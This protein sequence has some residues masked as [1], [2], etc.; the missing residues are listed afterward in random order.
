MFLTR[1]RRAQK[2]PSLCS[3]H[4]KTK[5]TLRKQKINQMLNKR[6]FGEEA[7][8]ESLKEAIVDF[9]SKATFIPYNPSEK[10]FK[11]L[12][13]ML[14]SMVSEQCNPQ[15]VSEVIEGIK[16][17]YYT[18]NDLS[19]VEK[20]TYDI[21][22]ILIELLKMPSILSNEECLCNILSTLINISTYRTNFTKEMYI[23]GIFEVIVELF[24]KYKSVF[25]NKVFEG[26][27]WLISNIINDDSQYVMILFNNGT[28]D[29]L[30]KALVT[31]PTTK[32][33]NSS[34]KQLFHVL[35]RMISKSYKE[36]IQRNVPYEKE[37][38]LSCLGYIKYFTENF[39]YTNSQ[40]LNDIM[41]NVISLFSLIISKNPDH[42]IL[43][44]QEGTVGYLL[45]LIDDSLETDPDIKLAILKILGDF[46]YDSDNQFCEVLFHN[47][48]LDRYTSM[49][50]NACENM[51]LSMDEKK[52][53]NEVFWTISNLSVSSDGCQINLSRIFEQ[54]RII[55][56]I[57]NSFSQINDP[58]LRKEIIWCLSTLC[59]TQ[60]EKNIEQLMSYGIIDKVFLSILKEQN[61]E[62]KKI[63]CVVVE[64]LESLV[65]KECVTLNIPQEIKNCEISDFIENMVLDHRNDDE[66]LCRKCESFL[67]V[68]NK[69][70]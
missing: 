57:F 70:N 30:A 32:F 38:F 54:K 18:T 62:D 22:K 47:R 16:E 60:E 49:I 66:D 17:F 39:L 58:K 6:R 48:I 3:I 34:L 19:E 36:K 68:L 1:E 69:V 9:H 29:F 8:S 42:L 35:Y 67:D 7:E 33:N 15:S 46:A 21:I 26:Y 61:Y 28:F 27:C 63:L 45:C 51:F 25:S 53:L 52:R 31:A 2:E 43:I 11:N 37:I 5:M 59:L 20:E 65:S 40:Y 64:A 14:Q 24:E 55:K 41:K 44:E 23:K 12:F 50:D 13:S 4:E 56:S 10:D